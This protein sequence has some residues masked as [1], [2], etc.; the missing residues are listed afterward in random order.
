M[1]KNVNSLV[2]SNH[3][4]EKNKLTSLF[5][6]LCEKS[7]ERNRQ[8]VELK[9]RRRELLRIINRSREELDSVVR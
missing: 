6:R 3:L 7:D 8:L 2:V 9:S 5:Y 1:T 4:K